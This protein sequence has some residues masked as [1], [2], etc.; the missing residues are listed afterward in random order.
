[1]SFIG[2]TTSIN[3]ADAYQTA[4]NTAADD[5][6]N[7]NTLGASR[8]AVLLTA[9]PLIGL[10]GLPSNSSGQASIQGGVTVNSIQR[11]NSESY[12]TLYRSANTS[13]NFFSIEQNQLSALQSAFSEPNGGISSLYSTFQTA[14]SQWA[15]QPTPVTTA[16]NVLTS[17][18]DLTG[19]LNALS[20]SVATQ[21]IQVRQAAASDVTTVNGLL[22]QIAG[23]NTQI[24]AATA[25]GS[26]PNTYLDQRDYAIDQLSQYVPVQ[27]SLQANGSVLVSVGGQALVNDSVAYHLS[28]PVIPASGPNAGQLVIGRTVDQNPSQPVALN[29]TGGELGAY[30]DLYNN[31]LSSYA[32]QLNT[33]AQSLASNTDSIT[34]AGFDQ[35]GNPGT[36]LFGAAGQTSATSTAVGSTPGG[37]SGAQVTAANISVLMTSPSQLPSAL[38]NTAAGTIVQPL[39]SANNSF[40]PTTALLNNP[41]LATPATATGAQSIVVSL[42]GANGEQV[43]RSFQY[44][45][46]SGG[47]G[48]GGELTLN[49]FINQ[50]N[51]AQLGVNASYNTTTQTVQF[52]RDPTTIGY[53]PGFTINDTADTPTP[54]ATSAPGILDAVGAGNLQDSSGGVPAIAAGTSATVSV[55]AAFYANLKVG[56]QVVVGANQGNAETV[57]ISSLSA[58]GPPYTFT[59][60]FTNAHAAGE[61]VALVQGSQ[62]AVGT[63]DNSAANDLSNMFSSSVA[64]P[65]VMYQGAQPLV[66]AAGSVQTLS[67][68][69]NNPQAFAGLKVGQ[70]LYLSGL[71][72]TAPVAPAP[73]APGTGLPLSSDT[74]TVVGFTPTG[75]LQI[76]LSQT[77]NSVAGWFFQAAPTQTL[78][79]YY[80]N[81]V[82]Q[83]GTDTQTAT[84]GTTTQ[85]SL[86]SSINS[87]RQGISG[88][89]VDEETQ[90]IVQFQAAYDAASK[91]F[92][93]INSLLGNVLSTLGGV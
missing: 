5:L 2:L 83:V 58:G 43:T 3:A 50:F 55:S 63:A 39:N 91:A 18:Q 31:K 30:L 66:G 80:G 40:D 47:T 25:V 52:Q 12:D 71:T 62:N 11:I 29:I 73:Y 16:Q 21:A 45:L 70:T 8:Q 38:A 42:T 9:A 56:E 82:T 36:P 48:P 89:N 35:S 54:P 26:N 51:A 20:T 1:M 69:A 19:A 33:F 49:D 84:T 27:S 78:S 22:D 68:P 67:A 28:A 15:S 74:A 81:L 41:S 17:A 53:L 13:Q 64:V 7:Q 65:Q 92:N 6:T 93:V 88:I 23:L 60:N 10:P 76:K 24:R 75:Q 37:Y 4:E 90:K 57:T 61:S 59:A 72:N 44:N 86:T 46:A 14:V 77:E 85:T 32:T 34:Q 79:N 87:T